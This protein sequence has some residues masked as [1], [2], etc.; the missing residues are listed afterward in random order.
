MNE[1]ENDNIIN[2]DETVIN[3]Q[4]TEN[5]VE[6]EQE[7]GDV[8]QPDVV[9]QSEPVIETG[10]EPEDGPQNFYSAPIETDS[11]NTVYE[12]IDYSA[13]EQVKEYDKMSK[14]LKVFCL[15]LAAVMLLTAASAT[16]YF[17][18]RESVSANRKIAA[19]KLDLASKPKNTDASSPAGV[20]SMINESVVGI[21][22][23]NSNGLMS[24]ASG[25]V[26]T[27]DGYIITNDHIYADIG[28]AKFKI[29]TY[30]GTQYDAEYVAG[31]AISDL[32]VLKI[33]SNVKLKAAT[34]GNSDELVCGEDVVAVGRPSDATEYSS[35]TSG[36]ISLTRRRVQTTT[37]YSA[38][39]IQTD[40]AINPGSSGGALVNM[41]GQV[42]GITSSKVAGAEYDD[43]GFAIPSVT[44]KR[45]VSQ[46]VKEGK[47][48]DR[49]K[50]GI[51][52]TEVDSVTAAI[53][54]NDITGLYV[55]EVSEDSD[56]Y[57]KV[58]AGDII[59]QINGI[60]ITSDEIVLDIIEDSRAG[61]TITLSVYTKNASTAD[62]TV[63]L[64]ANV[65]ESSYSDVLNSPSKEE[66]SQGGTFDFPFGE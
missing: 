49:A 1:F 54:G 64:K 61:D 6:A 34:F 48:V 12:K 62:Y 22:V 60:Q 28:A 14:G 63:K 55:A 27:E 29:F 8:A 24:D 25:V 57:G 56:I 37:S 30:D 43:I 3:A 10:V 47:V 17:F 42:I 66:S 53:N 35:I 51:S 44:V 31:D 39:L 9:P 21:R 59:T 20:Y 36:I 16:G 11:Q 38:S 32:A 52:Y 41:Y 19:A 65:G 33:T 4:V 2:S 13:V 40:S 58:S 50:L 5:V 18:G 7:N 23:Y 46:L 15:V 26:Y 45:V